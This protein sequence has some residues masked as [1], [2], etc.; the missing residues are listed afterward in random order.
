MGSAGAC[1]DKLIWHD[2]D[3]VV[4]RKDPRKVGTFLFEGRDLPFDGE[5]R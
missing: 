3:W 1:Q 4:G 2:D 5:V